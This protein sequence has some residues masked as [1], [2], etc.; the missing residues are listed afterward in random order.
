[1]SLKRA[2]GSGLLG[3]LGG[4]GAFGGVATGLTAASLPVAPWLAPLM[5][6]GG[7]VGS[8]LGDSADEEER[9]NDP[10]YQAAVRKN[11]AQKIVSQNLGRA[12]S[13]LKPKTMQEAMGRGI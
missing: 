11:N 2:L 8:L 4:A 3:G 10:E 13:G 6:G 7:V 12:F 5:I 1:M 9:K